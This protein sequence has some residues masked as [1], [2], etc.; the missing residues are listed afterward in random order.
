[1]HWI[2]HDWSDELC[3]SI[4]ANIVDA[5]EPGYPRLIIHESILPDLHCDLPSACLSIMMMVQVAALER[6]ERLWWDLLAY[7]GL[8]NVKFY[9]PPGSGDGIVEA[10]K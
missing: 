6:V 8:I 1:M 3:R 9:Q 7:V 5:M 10:I 4:L 2:I